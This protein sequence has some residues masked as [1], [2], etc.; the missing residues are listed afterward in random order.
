[1]KS[2]YKIVLMIVLIALSLSMVTV[3]S[4]ANDQQK[5]VQVPMRFICEA[6]GAK[7]AWDSGTKTASA[8]KDSSI[9]SINPEKRQANINGKTVDL[10]AGLQTVN[11]RIKVP[12]AI[13]NEAFGINI[14]TDDCV[15]VLAIVYMDLLSQGA[16]LDCA[17]LQNEY[18]NRD[19]TPE[20]MWQ[21]GAALA[22]MGT[23]SQDSITLN[24]NAV[25][26]NVAIRCTS[27]LA[28]QFDFV[29]RFDSELQIDDCMPLQID[30]PNMTYNSPDYDKPENYTEKE[31]KVNSCIHKSDKLLRLAYVG[32]E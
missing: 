7:V 29:V 20:M 2:L 3:A 26:Q 16:A 23:L 10:G 11:G 17:V 1:M 32:T 8:T 6:L 31:V 15:K 21:M 4:A 12:L 13:I 22:S 28:G 18:L 14:T 19:L 24:K 25:H 30:S 9:L 5:S 27:D